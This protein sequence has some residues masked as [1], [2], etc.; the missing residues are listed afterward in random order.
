MPKISKI[1][2]IVTQ[3]EW[4]GAQRYIFD[5]ANE[6]KAK[7]YQVAIAAGGDEEL[8]DKLKQQGIQTYQLKNLVREINPLKDIAA[9]FEIKK[10]LKN[11]APD[12]LHL[13][14]S[15]AGVIGAMA[16]RHTGIKK[17]IYTVHGF[18][19]NE[20]MSKL[21]KIIYVWAEKFSARYKNKLICVSEYDRQTG[22]QNKITNANKLITINNGIQKIDFNSTNEARLKLHLPENKIIVG[23]VANFYLTKGLSYL[24][25]ASKTVITDWPDILFVLVGDGRLR[26][27]LENKISELGLKNSF[28]LLGRQPSDFY[29]LLKAFDIYCSASVKE[30]LSYTILE[31]MQA[32]L[33]I[34]ATKVGGIPEM[35]QDKSNGLMVPPADKQALAGAIIELI[36]N[37]N[38]AATLGRQA[39]IDFENKFSLDKMIF[40]TEKVYRE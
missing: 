26:P 14:S 37:K 29:K 1:L 18:V 8:F 20:P 15:K 5:L 40:K 12:I 38:L 35:I 28:I 11:F 36:K 33:P 27:S 19:F 7:G 22:I 24:I 6:F 21:K 10:L 9:Y 23:T 13:N 17:I 2:Y 3:S 16:G 34:V 32:G 30:G 39:K 25:D 4:G 31:A